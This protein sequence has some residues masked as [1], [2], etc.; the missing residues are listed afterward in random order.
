M[1]RKRCSLNFNIF[2]SLIL[3]G[4]IQGFVFGVVVWFS[5]KYKSRSNYILAA[6]IVVYSLS[7][8]QYYLQ[9]VGLF[10]YEELFRS[11]HMPW[12]DLTP[13]LILFYVSS[14]LHPKAKFKNKELLVFLPFIFTLITGIFYKVLVR[15]DNKSDFLI[16]LNTFCRQYVAYY[17]DLIAAIV[18][19]LVIV[20]VFKKIKIYKNEHSNYRLEYVRLE[21][22]W[23]R[24]TLYILLVLIAIW[25]VL[26]VFDMYSEDGISFYPIWLGVAFLIYWLGHIGVYRYGITQE[27]YQLR[28]EQNKKTTIKQ[29]DNTKNIIIERLKHYLIGEKQFLEADLTLEKTAEALELSQGHLSKIINQEMQMSFKDFVNGLRVDEAKR[30]L[31]DGSF[32]NY[33]LLAIGLEAGFNSKSAFNSSFKKLTGLTPSEFKKK[34]S[35]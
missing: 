18:S 30:Y 21:L 35:S 33:T 32:S 8:L 23:L 22:N 34:L 7:N 1:H 16:Q 2:N 27:R 9:D 20:V 10:T 25:I 17:A 12:A 19:I 5:K 3:A 4:V 11:L 29:K 14:F 26:V 13:A 28:K 31:Q 15:I 24:K 6:L